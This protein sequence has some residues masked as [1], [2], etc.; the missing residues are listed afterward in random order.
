MFSI[1]KDRL[2]N[3]MDRLLFNIW[4]ELILLRENL[5]EQNKE[6]DKGKK[7]NVEI[8]AKNIIECKYCGGT[9]SNKGEFLACSRK[10]KKEGV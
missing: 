6:M 2:V 10:S 5:Q 1:K 4:Q 3:T 7:T 9:H 8:K